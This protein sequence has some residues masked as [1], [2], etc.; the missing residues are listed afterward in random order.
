MKSYYEYLLEATLDQTKDILRKAE[1]SKEKVDNLY[2]ELFNKKGLQTDS[3]KYRIYLPF[4]FDTTPYTKEL[5]NPLLYDGKKDFF[6]YRKE[7]QKLYDRDTET[8]KDVWDSFNAYMDDGIFQD[9]MDYKNGYF[10]DTQGRPVKI[11]KQLKKIANQQQN[12]RIHLEDVIKRFN[13]DRLRDGTSKYDYDNLMIVITK[14]PIDVINQSTDRRWTSCM[15]LDPTKQG[16][17]KNYVPADIKYGT[18]M[19]YLTNNNDYKIENPI[20]RISIKPY[21]G[22]LN[23]KIM[24]VTSSNCHETI[25]GSIKELLLV[26]F[27]YAV[28]SFIELNYNMKKIKKPEEDIYKPQAG[29]YQDY[30]DRKEVNRGKIDTQQIMHK[31]LDRMNADLCWDTKIGYWVFVRD[32]GLGI[33]KENG[34]IILYPTYDDITQVTGDRKLFI[35]KRNG[36][37]YLYDIVKDTNIYDKMNIVNMR[38]SYDHKSIEKAKPYFEQ[39]PDADTELIDVEFKDGTKGYMDLDGKIVLKY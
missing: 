21:K 23:D 28:Q 1:Y 15:D 4:S 32:N 9:K 26:E 22:L 14:N 13:E 35:V 30:D 5:E 37:Y 8:L 16:F 2:K 25:Y 27:R 19:A 10:F 34:K 18:I 24:L 31:T 11:A 3:R 38:D 39:N 17:Y 36:Y 12:I 29:L 20:A 33:I 6:E 7:V